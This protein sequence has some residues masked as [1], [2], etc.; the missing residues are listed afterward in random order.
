MQITRA[1][2][3]A[4]DEYFDE[5]NPGMGRKYRIR[6]LLDQHL[7]KLHFAQREFAE[8]RAAMLARANELNAVTDNYNQLKRHG[9]ILGK[10]VGIGGYEPEQPFARNMLPMPVTRWAFQ[11]I[12]V[13]MA[14]DPIETHYGYTIIAGRDLVHGISLPH[15]LL[16][17]YVVNFNTITPIAFDALWKERR[18][19]MQVTY[20]HPDLQGALPT[21]LEL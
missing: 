2:I 14:S 1:E 8:E 4:W 11:D 6:E 7:L 5:L 19:A 18:A 16:H 10:K 3:E 17:A 15:D 13:L 12:R 9:E 21:W 20:V